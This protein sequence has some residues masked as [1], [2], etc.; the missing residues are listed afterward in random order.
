MFT[1]LGTVEF[2][3]LPTAAL[4][5]GIAA[6]FLMPILLQRGL[7]PQL[8]QHW[9]P[10]FLVGLLNSAIPLACYCFALLTITTGLSSI[11]NATGST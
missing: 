8:L 10:V 11:I 4:R 1:R 2:G 3:A 9:K 6:L 5:V 7:G